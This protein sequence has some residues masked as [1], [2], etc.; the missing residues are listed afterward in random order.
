VLEPLAGVARRDLSD[1]GKHDGVPG[2][3]PVNDPI[4][5]VGIDLGLAE[6]PTQ[7]LVPCDMGVRPCLLVREDQ[8]PVGVRERPLPLGIRIAG[9]RTG[10][11]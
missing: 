2:V 4:G 10:S 5:F 11:L 7:R 1:L 8:I 6:Q 9:E 3:E